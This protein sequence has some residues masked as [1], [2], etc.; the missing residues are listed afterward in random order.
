MAERGAK[1]ATFA[2]G[3]HP[4]GGVLVVGFVGRETLGK[5][6]AGG[7]EFFDFVE[8][9]GIIF[10]ARWKAFH[11]RMFWFDV[12]DFEDATGLV[13]I[14]AHAEEFSPFVSFREAVAVHCAMEDDSRNPFIVM[15]F[16]DRFDPI[17]VR[18]LSGTF[19]VD[20]D[21]K[22]FAPVRFFVDAEFNVFIGAAAFVEDGP[23]DVCAS[24]DAFRKN[25]LLGVIIVATAAD[26]KE[27]VDGFGGSGRWGAQAEQAKAEDIA[28]CKL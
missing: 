14:G 20:N 3:V 26:D 11:N 1:D 19:V 6:R 2:V 12:H 9:V 24:A 23:G 25:F 10:P 16:G 8:F 21:I 15:F 17:H 27:S 18:D 28:N 4:D 5:R 7:P 13:L 22:P